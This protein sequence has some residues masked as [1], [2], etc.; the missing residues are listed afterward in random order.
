[1]RLSL[2]T[3][4]FTPIL[5]LVVIGMTLLVVFNDHATKSALEQ[6]ESQSMTQIGRAHV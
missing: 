3:K 2:R 4:F 1:M 6:V 5:A